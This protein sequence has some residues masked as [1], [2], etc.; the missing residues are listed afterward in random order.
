[1]LDHYYKVNLR[2]LGGPLNGL[3]QE[4]KTN[5]TPGEIM[6]VGVAGQEPH[7]YVILNGP[8]VALAIATGRNDRT[9]CGNAIHVAT[10]TPADQR[11][12]EVN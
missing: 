11:P 6:Q 12:L 8:A 7:P 3:E 10:I 9:L 5:L 1:M 2:L 4:F